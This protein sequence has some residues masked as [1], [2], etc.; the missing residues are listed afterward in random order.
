MPGAGGLAQTFEKRAR[1]G[2][3]GRVVFRMPLHGEG[4]ARRPLD[5]GGL[6]RAIGGPAIDYKGFPGVMTP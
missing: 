5:I 2:I 1:Y 3:M 6:R 4:I